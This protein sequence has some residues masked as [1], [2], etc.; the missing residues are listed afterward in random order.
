MMHGKFDSVSS[1][2]TKMMSNGNEQR[3]V[4]MRRGWAWLRGHRN[5]KKSQISKK[6]SSEKGAKI[7]KTKVS[8]IFYFTILLE[9]ILIQMSFLL[10][11]ENK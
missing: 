10:T 2:L 6:M 5:L 8:F 9:S 3:N 11:H 4:R 7:F 1:A